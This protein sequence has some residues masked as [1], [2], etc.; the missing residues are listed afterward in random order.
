M[1]S[2]L[3]I[4]QCTRLKVTFKNLPSVP[5]IVQLDPPLDD[6]E[7][8]FLSD[9]RPGTFIVSPR[10]SQDALGIG[11]TGIRAVMNGRM[12]DLV[13]VHGGIFQELLISSGGRTGDQYTIKMSEEPEEGDSVWSMKPV[14]K[15]AGGIPVVGER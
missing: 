13:D 8:E 2:T 14:D 11:L 4:A 3:E 5:E 1:S 10:I 12:F 9:A 15:I 7:F 6:V